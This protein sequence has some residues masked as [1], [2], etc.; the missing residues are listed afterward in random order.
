MT[1]QQGTVCKQCFNSQMVDAVLL[2]NPWIK[3]W[4]TNELH[5]DCLISNQ[6]WCCPEEKLQ[7]LCHCCCWPNC[8]LCNFPVNQS[9]HLTYCKCFSRNEE[10]IWNPVWCWL[11]NLFLCFCADVLCFDNSYSIL[12]SKRVSYKVEVLPPVEGQMQSPRS[13]G[14]QRLQWWKQRSLCDC[15]HQSLTAKSML[16]CQGQ[17]QPVLGPWAKM[18]SRHLLISPLL[19]VCAIHIYYF[20]ISI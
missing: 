9:L 10:F 18:S 1:C 2:K 8:L 14:D 6:L 17:L 5:L 4:C 11:V 3:A 13:R 7:K 19:S 20:V 12:H 16:L 15:V